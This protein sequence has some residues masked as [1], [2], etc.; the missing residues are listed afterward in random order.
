MN[1]HSLSRSCVWPAIVG[2]A[3]TARAPDLRVIDLQ[4]IGTNNTWQL[5]WNSTPGADYQLQRSKDDQL[6]VSTTNIWLPVVA[7]RAASDITSAVDAAGPDV[8]QRFY[9]VV[10]LTNDQ[11][12]VVSPVDSGGNAG[13][14]TGNAVLRVVI[15]GTQTVSS[16]VFLDGGNLL[17]NGVPGIGDSW[18]LDIPADGGAPR[19]R[20]V[21]AR[22]TTVEGTVFETPGSS[23]LQADVSKFVPVN[24]DG[25]RAYGQFVSVDGN[26]LLG[27]F[28]F[29][30]EGLGD[31]AR[32]T[33]AH[34]DFPPGGSLRN[35]AGTTGIDF[36]A[37][38]FF[39]GHE[40]PAPL[41]AG[42][43]SHTLDLVDVT[44]AAVAGALG[45]PGGSVLA[46]LWN[47]LPM[48]WHDGALTET[49]WAGLKVLPPIG[50]FQLPG[51]QDC[52][53]VSF[54]PKSGEPTL[55]LCFHGAWAPFPK[56]PQFRIPRAEPL[57]IYI[58]L[59]GKIAAH[60]TV[61]ATFAD[62]ATVRGSVSWRE[63]NFE[64]RF[65][66]R[67]IVIPA[68]V[69]LKRALPANPELCI[70]VGNS[71]AELDAAAKCLTSFRDTYRALAMGGAAESSLGGTQS[72]A[73]LAEPT[74]SVGTALAGWASRLASWRA[75][76]A[77]Q[78][79]DG[80]MKADLLKIA[81]N[82]ARTGEA[83]ADL[84]SVLKLLRG[85]VALRQHADTAGGT[86][87]VSA[88]EIA[89][90]RLF[91]AGERIAE[92]RGDSDSPETFAEAVAV[93]AASLDDTSGGTA[94]GLIVAASGG[95]PQ[96]RL[97]ALLSKI[98]DRRGITFLDR[99]LVFAGQLNGANNNVLRGMDSNELLDFLQECLDVLKAMRKE[100]LAT[101]VLDLPAGA[102][103]LREAL[104]QV[105]PHFDD[106]H[107]LLAQEALRLGDYGRLR[108]A[109]LQRA[110]YFALNA[111]LGE[112]LRS[113]RP[114]FHP[115]TETLLRDFVVK[116]KDR[117]R[118]TIASFCS[119]DMLAV[120]TILNDTLDNG[121]GS[122]IS[123]ARSELQLCVG[124]L[125]VANGG[126]DDCDTLTRELLLRGYQLSQAPP[127]SE[128]QRQLRI[129]GKYE[130]P[131]TRNF[132][133]FETMQLNLGGQFLSGRLQTHSPN[134]P[135]Y[136]FLIHGMLSH[137]S[138][139]SAEFAFLRREELPGG[140]VDPTI[141]GSG[142]ITARVVDGDLVV[143]VREFRS[144]GAQEV[145]STS[146]FVKKA[147]VAT[148]SPRLTA[149][150]TGEKH[151]DA[152][153]II[154][155]QELGPL[156][157]LQIK[158]LRQRVLG[159]PAAPGG[160][161]TTSTLD[162]IQQYFDA[163]N[164]LVARRVAAAN[165]NSHLAGILALVS[166]EQVPLARQMLRELLSRSRLTAE[167][168]T[169]NSWNWLRVIFSRHRA[170]PKATVGSF[171]NFMGPEIDKTF[172]GNSFKYEV[173]LI[174]A[175]A[176]PD[177]DLGIFEIGL[178]G[179]K[180]EI[181]KSRTD[182][183]GGTST[184]RLEG[185]YGQL[186]IGWSPN[187]LDFLGGAGGGTGGDEVTA[188]SNIDYSEQ[189]LQ[190]PIMILG[191][192]AGAGVGAT[193]AS[194]GPS[195]LF[196]YGT[197]ILP[198]LAFPLPF[199]STGDNEF[200]V[201]S[202]EVTFASG[203]LFADS[204]IVDPEQ[205]NLST[206]PINQAF[207]AQGSA[208]GSVYFDVNQAVLRTCGWVGLRELVAEYRAIFEN[209]G[210]TISVLGFADAT[211]SDTLNDDLSQRR[212]DS[213]KTALVNVVGPGR[214]VPLDRIR[215]VGLGRKPALGQAP[216]RNAQLNDVERD[217][218]ALKRQ[219]LG[220]LQ[221][222]Q[223]DQRW[224]SVSILLNN[225]IKVDLRTPGTQ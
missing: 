145:L 60:G 28:L 95:S 220:T 175:G 19:V 197:R 87:L 69:S 177:I 122:D 156:H 57:K 64:V 42:G 104:H 215:S 160:S 49:G 222:N 133:P 100:S 126:S 207:S 190:G 114:E 205:F 46:L 224:R 53:L 12:L 116:F 54:D 212:A 203:Y 184:I 22:V 59:S 142:T 35:L 128:G 199:T 73:P 27:H 194:V 47:G 143:D 15:G 102:P 24:A 81:E 50:D 121:S 216:T 217:F 152:S 52:A 1:W 188:Y 29:F 183:T 135:P 99:R 86:E 201:P 88:F 20:R 2:F 151:G 154:R 149:L 71:A 106:K 101:S 78:V 113:D 61:E 38:Q 79:L 155:A 148:V 146:R 218:I 147:D 204:A 187:A 159:T 56:G 62:G 169:L 213:V 158:L 139:N 193:S 110:R 153:E 55:I 65:Q 209:E 48:I 206:E 165:L 45:L 124:L 200:R 83:A 223:P 21:T 67:N 137:E 16:V 41:S 36:T 10:E 66:G 144:V 9:R 119:G 3:M 138:A 105:R 26:G 31:A 75:D 164:T 115:N 58:S 40:D 127:G 182:G 80:A 85:V 93:L 176:S 33:G 34:F 17:G 108:A 112:R 180:V 8:R 171:R 90:E 131:T 167:G 63:P 23:F 68:L 163:E 166:T 174:D 161:R 107:S 189:S 37:A 18:E 141:R 94:G 168:L 117:P 192:S 7:V 130:K 208:Q 14:G 92:E 221:P 30:P 51:T 13:S 39:R 196:M 77:G 109:V 185:G 44:P 132:G 225:L 32:V 157:T 134:A 120:E 150:F 210:A 179:V 91:R 74:D 173:K 89:Q 98:R 118:A 4:R 214:G 11:S 5:R 219:E 43:G 202:V 136:R 25:S 123:W 129:T 96:A 84:P 140:G 111:E 72:F 211:G 170:D 97:R 6:P 181:Q 195:A 198:P 76:R 186:G 191:A 172:A 125:G 82:A 103:P 162:L 70:P 178:T